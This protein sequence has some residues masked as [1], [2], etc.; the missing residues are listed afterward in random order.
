MAK[1]YGKHMV[2]K[3]EVVSVMC[4]ACRKIEN[5]D[6]DSWTEISHSHRDWG[7]D[8]IESGVHL[9]ACSAECLAKLLKE[10]VDEYRVE[11]E[12]TLRVR[13]GAMDYATAK[14]LGALISPAESSIP[15]E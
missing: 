14:A 1:N 9:V 4:D 3:Y 11:G 10:A 5:G 2:E 8:S 13:I 7:N 6:P 15:N 12:P